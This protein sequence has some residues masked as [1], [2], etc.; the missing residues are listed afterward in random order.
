MFYDGHEMAKYYQ[1]LDS[2][3]LNRRANEADEA[4]CPQKSLVLL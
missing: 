4:T 3:E 2:W 1:H